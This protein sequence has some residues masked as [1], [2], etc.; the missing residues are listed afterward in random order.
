M[1]TLT[2]NLAVAIVLTTLTACASVPPDGTII[3]IPAP[4][5]EPAPVVE[6]DIQLMIRQCELEQKLPCINVTMPFNLFERA[7]NSMK[8]LDQINQSI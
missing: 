2:S 4:E 8:Q 3:E 5:Q 1:K 6:S 7:M